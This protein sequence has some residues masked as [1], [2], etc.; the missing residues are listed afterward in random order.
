MYLTSINIGRKTAEKFMKDETEKNF[1][2]GV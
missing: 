1:V 2:S